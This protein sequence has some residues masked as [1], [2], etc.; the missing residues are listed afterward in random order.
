MS[1]AGSKSQDEVRRKKE[2]RDELLS[3]EIANEA[4]NE[5]RAKDYKNPHAPKEVPPQYKTVAEQQRDIMKLERDALKM[6]EDIQI[7][8]EEA[9][10]VV[11]WLREQPDRLAKFVAYGVS[12]R[13]E[14]LKKANP[15]LIDAQYI[16]N[17]IRP[18]LLNSNIA[19]GFSSNGT[20]YNSLEAILR[21][22]NIDEPLI[23]L[24]QAINSIKPN[25]A[26]NKDLQLQL[27]D[28]RL[29]ISA[30]SQAYPNDE[31]FGNI[32]LL[33]IPLQQD[34]VFKLSELIK[35][36]SIPTATTLASITEAVESLSSSDEES[37]TKLIKGLQ[38][39]IGFKNE[40]IVEDFIKFNADLNKSIQLSQRE[41]ADVGDFTA[42][43]GIDRPLKEGQRLV[44]VIKGQPVGEE[45]Y[46]E[47]KALISTPSQNVRTALQF[48]LDP[49][50]DLLAIWGDAEKA[51]LT[52]GGMNQQGFT[53]EEMAYIKRIWQSYNEQYRN[54]T[55]E[56]RKE[57]ETLIPE[58]P[59]TQFEL[60]VDKLKPTSRPDDLIQFDRFADLLPLTKN[61]KK[62]EMLSKV[63][64][65][66]MSLDKYGDDDLLF[67]QNYTDALIYYKAKIPQDVLEQLY[68]LH[69]RMN[70]K[71][72]VFE[73]FNGFE[74]LN[75]K[76]M[77]QMFLDI[78]DGI[79]KEIDQR[80][81]EV[82]AGQT[83]QTA[84]PAKP[85]MS[86]SQPT[87]P[88]G[89]QFPPRA[90]PSNPFVNPHIIQLQ[91]TSNKVTSNKKREASAFLKGKVEE[92]REQRAEERKPKP[93]ELIRGE[94]EAV[95][96]FD[97]F[98]VELDER[99][100]DEQK[101]ILTNIAEHFSRVSSSSMSKKELKEHLTDY[102][103]GGKTEI[104]DYL[105]QAF[106]EQSGFADQKDK[107]Y[108]PTQFGNKKGK[109]D[110]K[111]L[112]YG[113]GK[114]GRGVEV[115]P[116]APYKTFGKFLIHVPSLH[117]NI[118]NFK[119]P[120]RAS[121][122]HIKRKQITD[123]YKEFLKDLLEN[124]KINEREYNRLCEEEKD[125][126]GSIVKGAGLLEH[127]KIKPPKVD[128][129]DT[130]RYELLI[131]EY[132]AGNNS[133]VMLK[134][135]RSLIIKFMDE[136]KIKRKDGQ[137]LLVDLSV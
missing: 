81:K 69:K 89:N 39:K 133:P 104:M 120:S 110:N 21:D 18:V 6:L 71:D 17:I 24:I 51:V 29:S 37:T 106:M 95:E 90:L 105:Q 56:E 23:N 137:S 98:K 76:E 132:K 134:E 122:P 91:A 50:N 10:K 121:I 8:Y 82:K 16:I 70:I 68:E 40:K 127:F 115:E 97:N 108:K 93:K 65:K 109:T 84:T 15:R 75:P 83:P 60:V 34:L 22:Y 61:L 1:L 47:Q 130:S 74:R 125:H 9:R 19:L 27:N 33:Q 54:M 94:A 131:G 11:S 77:G 59:K 13:T 38:R 88:R 136:G 43:A 63:E 85:V 114:I 64:S 42:E 119:Y 4:E 128:K 78:R 103:R 100:V 62:G 66:L 20:A 87:L 41:G 123:D 92:V 112:K 86:G 32:K 25:G 55:E 107:P 12:I 45:S 116:A 35:K 5:R 80:S 129:G 118:A 72:E 14:I 30:L 31:D 117:D 96:Q 36:H 99:P 101:K 48:I 111:P 49:A 79:V 102:E 73:F 3:I 26:I 135:L 44:N 7:D 113:L 67:L 124:G 28:L 2:L 57:Q 52:I 126:F 46:T 53:P 58:K